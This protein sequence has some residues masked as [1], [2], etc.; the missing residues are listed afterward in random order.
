[1]PHR[2]TAGRYKCLSAVTPTGGVIVGVGVAVTVGVTVGVPVG[3]ALAA[4]RTSKAASA[5]G[6][7]TGGGLPSCPNSLNP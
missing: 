3:G 2:V 4:Q 7:F 5:W 6:G 1:M